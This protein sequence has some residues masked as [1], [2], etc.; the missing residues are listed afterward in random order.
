MRILARTAQIRL[1]AVIA[2]LVV[3]LAGTARSQPPAQT[4]DVTARY[5]KGVDRVKTGDLTL[6]KDAA[7]HDYVIVKGLLGNKYPGY[8]SSSVKQLQRAGLNVKFAPINTEA[9]SEK[10]SKVISDMIKNAKRPIV[11]IGHSKGVVDTSDA[12][13]ELA[14]KDPAL[15]K[16]NVSAFVAI[17]GPYKGTPIADV[18]MKTKIG[19][20]LAGLVGKILRTDLQAGDDLTTSRREAKIAESPYP[21]HLVPTLSLATERL[22]SLSLLGPLQLFLKRKHGFASDG[23]V[24]A[25]SSVIP[26]SAV[27]KDEIDHAQTPYGKSAGH[28]TLS[29][30]SLALELRAEMLEQSIE[31]ATAP[32]PSPN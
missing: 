24:P 27:A 22:S 30:V 26:G 31:F 8:M 23:L 19:R 21:A 1:L 32:P 28:R 18:I 4:I 10:N 6:P 14:K 15:V 7:S 25:H 17:Q 16:R 20:S 13:A 3:G 5:K 11:F 12:I 2:V 29:L 9:S